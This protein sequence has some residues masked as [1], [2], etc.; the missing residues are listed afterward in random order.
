MLRE[1]QRKQLFRDNINPNKNIQ[2]ESSVTSGETTRRTRRFSRHYEINR[3]QNDIVVNLSSK[4]LKPD[5]ICILSKGLNFCPTPNKINEEQLSADLDKF[6]RSFRI[7]EYFLAKERDFPVDGR[8]IRKIIM[9]S[10]FLGLRKKSS[11]NPKPS[12]N[13]TLESFIDLAKM[14]VQTAASTNIPTHNNLTP[15]K[16]VRSK[17]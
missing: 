11:W 16:R 14:D 2:S 3:E 7:K 4:D 17:N 12:K 15:E 10:P 9:G 6:A 5:E 8:S 13:T 1:K